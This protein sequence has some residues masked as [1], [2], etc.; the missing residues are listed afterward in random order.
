M[1]VHDNRGDVSSLIESN[2]SSSSSS[3][4][5]RNDDRSIENKGQRVHDRKRKHRDD[6]YTSVELDANVRSLF[7]SIPNTTSINLDSSAPSSSN[8]NSMEV[9]PSSDF[10]NSIISLNVRRDLMIDRCKQTESLI[11]E[12]MQKIKN[13]FDDMDEAK[14]NIQKLDNDIELLTMEN[15]RRKRETLRAE[16]YKKVNWIFTDEACPICLEHYNPNVCYDNCK[17]SIC[18]NCNRCL[19]KSIKFPTCP[20]CR[21]EITS[22]SVFNEEK[23]RIQRT[24]RAVVY[25]G[26]TYTTSLNST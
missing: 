19:L 15:K 13:C 16:Y 3:Y 21:T 24:R 4:G 17:H 23:L 6:L 1:S 9:E 22:Y 8:H 11:S 10:Q 26:S 2:P 25:N 12:Y 18:V 14:S 5:S 7:D 20:L